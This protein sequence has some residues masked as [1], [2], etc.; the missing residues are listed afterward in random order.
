LRP[1][2]REVL[3][4]LA[5][6]PFA[7]APRLRLGPGAEAARPA[8]SG[9]PGHP[10]LVRARVAKDRLGKGDTGLGRALRTTFVRGSRAHVFDVDT[11]AALRIARRRGRA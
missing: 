5:D 9:Q 3:I 8:F 4:F 11:V 10:L 2:E 1:I 7:R 6:M